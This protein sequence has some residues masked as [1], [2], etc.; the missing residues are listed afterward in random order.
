MPFDASFGTMPAGDP[1]EAPQP[2]SRF[3]IAVLADFS[4]RQN[5]G[6]TYSLADR[7]LVRVN[8]ENLDEVMAKLAVRLELSVGNIGPAID[9]SFALLDDFHPDRLHDRVSYVADA[10]DSGSKSGWLN[11]V[12]HHPDFQALESTWRGLDWLLARTSKGGKVEVLLLD[13]S[14]AELSADLMASE[15]LAA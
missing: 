7:R 4:G 14:L 10:D 9:L 3:R 8:R 13:V 1:I 6:E 15:E 11:W 12:L 5:R 2:D